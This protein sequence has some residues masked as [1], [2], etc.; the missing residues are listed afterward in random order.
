MAKV[1]GSYTFAGEKVHTFE[2]VIAAESADVLGQLTAA[3][4]A[5]KV[6]SDRFLTE[7]IEAQ[8]AAGEGTDQKLKK[9]AGK[10]PPAKKARKA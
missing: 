4:E 8:N 6:E 3:L 1:S 5:A 2:T 7:K 9:P 10:G